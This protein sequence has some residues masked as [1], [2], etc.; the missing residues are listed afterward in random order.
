MSVSH[1][2]SSEQPITHEFRSFTAEAPLS[3]NVLIHINVRRAI[4]M[5]I[6]FYLA[7]KP[8]PSL[9]SSSASLNSSA[10]DL[11][12]SPSAPGSQIRPPSPPTET[13]IGI[14]YYKN[15][16]TWIITP[17]N[18]FGF[19]PPE[20]FRKVEFVK[21]RRK[22]LH[23]LE[24]GVV[25]QK[26]GDEKQEEE[27]IQDLDMES[28]RDA[29]KSGTSSEGGMIKHLEITEKNLDQFFIDLPTDHQSRLVH[30]DLK[31]EALKAL[32]A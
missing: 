11:S 13:P 29:T 24:E 27:A 18:E 21:I 9:R 31:K 28:A 1:S 22:V 30:S 6:R 20:C 14:L 8:S 17:G 23:T 4:H 16:L 7:S 3:K 32:S 19:L 2:H 15:R 10:P 25:K 26:P 5:G 12:D